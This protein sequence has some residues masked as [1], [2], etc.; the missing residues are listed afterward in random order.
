MGLDSTIVICAVAIL[1]LLAFRQTTLSM[2]KKVS[3]VQTDGVRTQ[4]DLRAQIDHLQLE[5]NRLAKIKFADENLFQYLRC[6]N[7]PQSPTCAPTGTGGTVCRSRLIDC[8]KYK[9]VLEN[10]PVAVER[11]KVAS[12]RFYQSDKPQNL[13]ELTY[14]PTNN[15]WFF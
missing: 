2:S 11:M 13:S 10:D 6:L 15:W 4:A 8:N 3:Q 1:L 14:P 7:V 5:N 12:D 9:L